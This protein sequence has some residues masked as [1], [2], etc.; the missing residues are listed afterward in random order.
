MARIDIKK[1][2]PADSG[3]ERDDTDDRVKSKSH[4]T[5]SQLASDN[6]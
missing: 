2:A 1:Q 4:Y 5:N 6:Y 3:R